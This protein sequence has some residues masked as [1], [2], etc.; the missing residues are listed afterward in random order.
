M[1]D[2]GASASE[3]PRLAF[4]YHPRS[5][6]TMAIAEAA[7]G[8]CEL[9][10]IVD[11]SDPE[12]S[13][14][15]RLLRRLGEVVD[16]AGCSLEDAAAAI[17]ASQPDGIL[18]LADSLLLWTA[19]V[20]A[21]L[22]LPFISPEVA[23]RLTDKYAQRVALQQAGLP[24]PGFWPIPG[25]D[26]ADA[27]AAFERTARFPAVLKPRSGEGSRDVVRVE[28]FPQLRAMVAADSALHL[29]RAHAELVLE[30]YLRDRPEA[31]GQQFADYVSVE[32]VVSAGQ[33]VISRSPGAFHPPSRSARPASSFPVPSTG[34][35]A[36]PSPPWQQPPFKV[37]ASR[38]ARLHTEVK[39]TPDGPRVI[40]VNGRIGGGVP[41]MLADATGVELLPIAIRL[42]LGRGDRVR[43]HAALSADRLPAVRTG[44]LGD[45][46]DPRR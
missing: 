44:A 39:M 2:G 16:V 45:A 40:E 34:T 12:I 3:R 27:W 32:S 13:S 23:E 26:D 42:A 21:A 10:W 22:D 35:S 15:V 5:F 38:S 43:H 8:I 29:D 6:G 31:A 41:E 25:R 20:A 7:E 11:T 24:V 14:M 37:S 28:S 18:A 36:Q 19:R 30:E 46:H 1:S 33:S 17:A 4:V 9:L